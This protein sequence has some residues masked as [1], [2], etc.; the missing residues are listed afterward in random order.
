MSS[1]KQMGALALVTCV[2]LASSSAWASGLDGKKGEVNVELGDTVRESSITFVSEAPGE[3]IVGKATGVRGEV[4]FSL[5]ELEKTAGKIAIPV[6][7]MNTG[8]SQRDEHMRGKDW[9]NAAANPSITFTLTGLKD[10]KVAAPEKGR[11]AFTAVAVGEISINGVSKEVTSDVKVTWLDAQPNGK[12]KGDMVRVE[13]KLLVKLA[14]HKVAGKRGVV[15][16][17]VGETI[18]IDMLLYG[19]AK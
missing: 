4:R 13:G 19:H 14:D 1:S 7:K 6:E 17:K 10:I 3:K 16:D 15:G 8:N 5:H 2:A 11:Q 12:V 18:Q 9:L